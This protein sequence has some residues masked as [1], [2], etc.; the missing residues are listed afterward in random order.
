MKKYKNLILEKYSDPFEWSIWCRYKNYL[1]VIGYMNYVDRIHKYNKHGWYY[2]LN[3][4]FFNA[5]PPFPTNKKNQKELQR[6][7]LKLFSKVGIR[8]I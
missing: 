3:K 1:L 8:F 7:D 5:Y 4:N 2:S 6:L